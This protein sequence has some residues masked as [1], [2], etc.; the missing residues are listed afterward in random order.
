MYKCLLK[1]FFYF[2]YN[3]G[4]P[5]AS[6]L[7]ACTFLHL[8]FNYL[9]TSCKAFTVLAFLFYFFFFLQQNYNID[10][11]TSANTYTNKKTYNNSVIWAIYVRFML[12]EE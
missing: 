8:F 9:K 12:L 6:T 4:N 1:M 3:L 2:F 7:P 11:K 5:V 10:N